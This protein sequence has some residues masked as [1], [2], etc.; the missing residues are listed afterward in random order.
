MTN[1]RVKEHTAGGT[2]PAGQVG[3]KS[4]SP[5]RCALPSSPKPRL[6]AARIRQVRALADQVLA[7]LQLGFRHLAAV[8]AVEAERIARAAYHVRDF[9]RQ[10]GDLF[11]G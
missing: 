1:Q 5:G 8:R 9:R 7:D 4:P 6:S 10:Q 11:Y 3:R 2:S